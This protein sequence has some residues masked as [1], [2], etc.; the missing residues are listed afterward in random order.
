VSQR[1]FPGDD[2]THILILSVFSLYT[3]PAVL[4]ARAGK[5][6]AELAD[7][8]IPSKK[9]AAAAGTA[10]C[11]PASWGKQRDPSQVPQT[12]KLTQLS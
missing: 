3:L 4:S 5:N 1:L 12:H 8:C 11:P 10:P 7:G 9:L 6:S 2:T